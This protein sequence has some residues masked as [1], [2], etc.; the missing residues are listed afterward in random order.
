MDQEANAWW[1]SSVLRGSGAGYM[2]VT[3]KRLLT[4]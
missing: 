3:G 4:N 1:G 2:L